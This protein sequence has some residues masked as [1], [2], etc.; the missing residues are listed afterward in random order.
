MEEIFDALLLIIPYDTIEYITLFLEKLPKDYINEAPRKYKLMYKAVKASRLDVLTLLISYGVEIPKDILLVARR[1]LEIAEFLLSKGAK[2]DL[3]DGRFL[4]KEILIE[5]IRSM[6]FNRPIT[7]ITILYINNVDL[8]KADYLKLCIMIK[9]SIKVI[10]LLIEKITPTNDKYL[11]LIINNNSLNSL[12][13]IEILTRLLNDCKL[14]INAENCL[15]DT[16]INNDIE[17]LEFLLD[18]GADPN[19]PTEYNKTFLQETINVDWGPVNLD[20]LKLLLNKGADPNDN[21]LFDICS[22]RRHPTRQDLE[23]LKILVNTPDIDLNRKNEYGSTALQIVCE[24]IKVEFI[25]ILLEGGAAPSGN[26]LLKLCNIRPLIQINQRAVKCLLKHGANPNSDENKDALLYAVRKRDT[27]IVNLLIDYGANSRVIV[28]PAFEVYLDDNDS[29]LDFTVES[30]LECS[31]RLMFDDITK[32]CKQIHWKP[33]PATNLVN[34]RTEKPRV[35]ATC[36]VVMLICERLYRVSDADVLPTELWVRILKF[37]QLREMGTFGN[38]TVMN[39]LEPLEESSNNTPN[40]SFLEGGVVKKKLPKQIFNLMKKIINMSDE[41]LSKNINNL[42]GCN[43]YEI[44]SLYYLL[45]NTNIEN[46]KKTKRYI[47][48]KNKIKLTK[49]VLQRKS[50]RTKKSTVKTAK[51]AKTAKSTAKTAKTAKSTA[52]TAKY[53][54]KTI[55]KSARLRKRISF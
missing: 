42:I 55:K 10:M 14:N 29:S 48:M 18:N 52:K 30:A 46:V 53:T 37:I 40:L 39:A 6:G 26:L 51:T 21:S 3:D 47:L 7:D 32:I 22:R 54:A 33:P 43:I 45:C 17:L 25:E 50:L 4:F 5:S 34:F 35:F 8:T 11:K 28:T 44:D 9:S 20:I 24:Y 2:L 38:N 23:I 31:E 36:C 15:S 41:E 1:N 27:D 19:I 13:K 16:I 12:G 49:F